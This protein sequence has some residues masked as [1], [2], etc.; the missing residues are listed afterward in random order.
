MKRLLVGA[1]LG[2]LGAWVCLTPA[3]YGQFGGPL[4]APR[5]G[6]F[7]YGAYPYGYA[8]PFGGYG[9]VGP[10]G[11]GTLPGPFGIGGAGVSPY[12]F[13]PQ[14]TV[15]AYTVDPGSPSITGHPTRFASYMRYFSSQGGGYV[16]PGAATP[17]TRTAPAATPAAFGTGRSSTLPSRSGSAATPPTRP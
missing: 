15:P 6:T 12:T 8:Y 3:A 17:A 10:Y 16:M 4:I 7:G 14:S 11:P 13:I 1:V 2:V 5:A 9:G